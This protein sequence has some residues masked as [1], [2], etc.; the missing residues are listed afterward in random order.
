LRGGEVAEG[1]LCGDREREL[2]R[3][4]ILPGVTGIDLGTGLPRCTDTAAA[5]AAVHDHDA[6]AISTS[7]M[8]AWMVQGRW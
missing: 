6:R 4:D 2:D 8:H 5:A 3:V 7:S 1:I